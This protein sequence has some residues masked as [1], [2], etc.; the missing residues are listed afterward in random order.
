MFDNKRGLKSLK[1]YLKK[2]YK[3]L[4]KLVLIFEATGVYSNY[5]KEFCA[6]NNL[7]AYIINPKRSS[8]FSKAIGN[9]SKTDKIDTKRSIYEYRRIIDLKDIKIPKIDKVAKCYLFTLLV[10]NLR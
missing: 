9:R 5:L 1:S 7:K 8:N 4:S 6:E 2:K 10:I 3:D